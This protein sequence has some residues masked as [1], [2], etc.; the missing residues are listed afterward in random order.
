MK[1]VEGGGVM[2]GLLDPF[3][4][5]D[6]LKSPSI[7]MWYTL[8][9]DWIAQSDELDCALGGPEMAKIEV[10]LFVY[11]VI[12]IVIFCGE[13][14]VKLSNMFFFF[15]GEKMPNECREETGWDIPQPTKKWVDFFAK[16]MFWNASPTGGEGIRKALPELQNSGT[17][18]KVLAISIHRQP[19][20][21]LDL[22]DVY[23]YN[24]DCLHT[25]WC[26]AA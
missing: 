4:M 19:L 26:I 5:M 9:S 16:F 17:H 18:Q 24:I 22:L 11:R 10:L 21:C 23:V 15:V 1:H 6:R 3:L 20:L 13:V 14:V 8:L 25:G 7:P 12:Y 2:V